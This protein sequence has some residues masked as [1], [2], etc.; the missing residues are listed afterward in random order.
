MPYKTTTTKQSKPS[1][2]WLAEMA[3][4]VRATEGKAKGPNSRSRHTYVSAH[5]AQAIARAAEYYE[6]AVQHLASSDNIDRFTTPRHKF[7]QQILRKDILP[8]LNRTER[9]QEHVSYAKGCVIVTGRSRQ[10]RA[11]D[12]FQRFYRQ[13]FLLEPGIEDPNNKDPALEEL[14]KGFTPWQLADLRTA[15]LGRENILKKY[16]R[17]HLPNHASKL[18]NRQKPRR[19]V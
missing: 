2:E 18:P 11:E 3:L 10:D 15:F 4:K 17:G 16:L 6:A 14:Q 9:E 19:Q 5:D 12:W 13:Y 7:I 1:A 8:K